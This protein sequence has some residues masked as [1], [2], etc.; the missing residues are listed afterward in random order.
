MI[1][2]NN[3]VFHYEHDQNTLNHIDLHIKKNEKI[4]IIGKSGCGKTTLLFLLAGILKPK[5][6]Q[7]TIHDKLLDNVRKETGIIFQSGGLFPWK[8]VYDNLALGLKQSSLTK[9]EMKRRIDQ[10]LETL[11]ILPFK[12]RYMKELSGGQKQRVAIARVLVMQSD[13]LLLD[14]PSSALDAM[15]KDHFQNT[16]LHLYENYSMTSIIVTHD[17]EEAV[18]L[19][20]RIIIMKDGMI[21]SMI[22]NDFYGDHDSKKT[23]GFYEKCIEVRKR[24]ES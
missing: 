8:T 21:D 10:V 12:H 16:L 1:K 19:G 6:G 13:L 24:L 5:Q 9:L 7:I 23:L 18:F 11:D 14:E 15:T 17:I 22:N 4:S 2:I 20:Q 3:L